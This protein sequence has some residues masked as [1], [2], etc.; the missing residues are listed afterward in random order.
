MITLKDYLEKEEEVA[1]LIPHDFMYYD[2]AKFRIDGFFGPVEFVYRSPSRDELTER[3]IDSHF[4]AHLISKETG[5]SLFIAQGLT[6]ETALESLYQE[7]GKSLARK[8][9]L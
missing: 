3:Y 5:K 9:S 2:C 4:S 7:I 8:E 1:R 6:P